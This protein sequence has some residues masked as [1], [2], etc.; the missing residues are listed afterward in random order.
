MTPK[1]LLF[2]LSLFLSTLLTAQPTFVVTDP[3][4][5]LKEA[6]EL[7]AKNQYP[8]AYPLVRDL[9]ASLPASRRSDDPFYYDDVQYYDLVC[10]LNLQMG[11]A[12][13]E[14]K[15]FIGTAYNVP[16]SQMLAFHLGHYYFT[17]DEFA[18]GVE[19]FN[20]AGNDNLTNDQIADKKFELGYCHFNL[21]DFKAATPLFN[22]VR[23]IQGH[24]Y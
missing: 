13:E 6:A 22:E 3:A 15:L 1:I 23:Q 5:K 11:D 8:L 18:D 9:K 24:K 4:R 12:A 7:M 21:K 16:R 10:R 19:W 14:A 2:S 20:R 17:T